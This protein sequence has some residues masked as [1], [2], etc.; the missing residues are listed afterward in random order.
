M[1]RTTQLTKLKQKSQTKETDTTRHAKEWYDFFWR[2]MSSIRLIGESLKCRKSPILATEKGHLS[3]ISTKKQ[4]QVKKLTSK[5]SD[6]WHVNS[7]MIKKKISTMLTV[8]ETKD[9]QHRDL[10]SL[11]FTSHIRGFG[12]CAYISDVYR[13]FYLKLSMC[14]IVDVTFDQGG[15]YV[16]W[17]DL[18]LQGQVTF[19]LHILLTI[20]LYFFL[21][22][23]YF[24]AY[25]CLFQFIC[26][27]KVSL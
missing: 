25:M 26:E 15:L 17:S 6:F 12:W 23:V 2:C 21:Q 9:I 1:F 4:L 20:P 13:P 10:Q 16:H 7:N 27:T 18:D 19:V 22:V 11:I 14:I 3:R 24:Y 5:F 8:T